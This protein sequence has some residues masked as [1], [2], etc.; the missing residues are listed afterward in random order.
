[1]SPG[2]LWHSPEKFQF[3]GSAV[4]PRQSIPGDSDDQTDSSR[5]KGTPISLALLAN[6]AH[7][8]HWTS[9]W[10]VK[11]QGAKGGGRLQP[12]RI[13]P[14]QGEETV[15]KMAGPRK[16]KVSG[17]GGTKEGEIPQLMGRV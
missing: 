7:K 9:G 16:G 3:S 12:Y 13:P 15:G 11:A 6:G 1:M 2:H 17:C 14:I 5:I 10:S 8:Y 4:R